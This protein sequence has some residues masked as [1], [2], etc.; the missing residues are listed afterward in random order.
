MLL[1]I[2]TGKTLE[3]WELE[4]Y[5]NNYEETNKN[6]GVGETHHEENWKH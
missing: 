2:A 6:L 1:I 3:R 5:F 4:C